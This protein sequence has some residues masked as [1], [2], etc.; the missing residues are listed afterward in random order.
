MKQNTMSIKDITFFT[1][2][3]TDEQALLVGGCKI[4]YPD[5][6]KVKYPG[7]CGDVYIEDKDKIIK[8][9]KPASI[10]LIEP[11]KPNE[12]APSKTITPVPKTGG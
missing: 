2:L 4:T 6:T 5:G 7:R 1:E 8:V 10:Q 11:L 12:L 3:T 9:T